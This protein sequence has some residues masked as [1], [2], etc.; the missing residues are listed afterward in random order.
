VSNNVVNDP[1]TTAFGEAQVAQRDPEFQISAEYDFIFR[2][3]TSDP[4][5]YEIYSAVIDLRDAGR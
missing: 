4:V 2:L 1:Q 5:A 3:T